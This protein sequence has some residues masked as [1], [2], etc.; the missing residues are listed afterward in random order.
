[1][2]SPDGSQSI[3]M[4]FIS[5]VFSLDVVLLPFFKNVLIFGCAGS[6]LLC[7]GFSPVVAHGDQAL[8]AVSRL[9]IAVVSLVAAHGF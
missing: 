7:T 5:L 9:L 1:M 6:L 3:Q 2:G 4:N 8:V